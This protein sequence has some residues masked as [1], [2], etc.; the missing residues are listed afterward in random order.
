MSQLYS[1]PSTLPQMNKNALDPTALISPLQNQTPVS[2]VIQSQ[3]LLPPPSHQVFE[4]RISQRV[5]CNRCLEDRE[6]G[7]LICWKCFSPLNPVPQPLTIASSTMPEMF[8]Q[9]LQPLNQQ[10]FVQLP[11]GP[12][13]PSSFPHN[14]FS[15]QTPENRTTIS[16]QQNS[17]MF[18]QQEHTSATVPYPAGQPIKQHTPLLTLV[19]TPASSDPLKLVN[20]LLFSGV[21]KSE[22]D[23]LNLR[24]PSVP[25]LNKSWL[26]TVQNPLTPKAPTVPNFAFR[27]VG[28]D[29]PVPS[30]SADE[31]KELLLNIRPDEDIKVEDKDAFV[32]GLATH[33]RLMK[34]QQVVL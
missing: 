9:P 6:E 21:I 19:D 16:H 14:P 11:F 29:H 28:W 32:P 18:P 31:I 10:L 1:T 24:P 26:P 3:S 2:P 5:I 25:L 7:E 15:N 20:S 13:I 23:I 27:G 4:S 17:T 30:P 8:V 34:H 12:N 33:M 22:P